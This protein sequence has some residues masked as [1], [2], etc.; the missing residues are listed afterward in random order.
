MLEQDDCPYCKK[1]DREIAS[2]YPKTDEGK[3]APLRRLMLG[4]PW[5]ED[6]SQVAS[7]SVTPTFILVDNNREIGRLRGYRGDEFF[8]VLLTEIFSKLDP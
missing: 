5:P 2:I 8:W 3:R 7:D 4:Q 6:L 1:F